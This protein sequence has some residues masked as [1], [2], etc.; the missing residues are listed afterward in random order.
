MMSIGSI[1][2]RRSSTMAFHRPALGLDRT[3]RQIAK[4]D[5]NQPRAPAGSGR[6]SGQWTQG[7]SSAATSADED[8]RVR[9]AGDVI[10]V[11]AL[12]GRS[13]SRAEGGI[14]WTTRHFESALGN[15]L[16]SRPG[17]W[18]CPPFRPVL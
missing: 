1:W 6:E 2:P 3:L 13:V 10:H 18:E 4:Y 17:V 11:G 9:L 14:P 16:W 5:P 8:H 7:G 12:V 15:F